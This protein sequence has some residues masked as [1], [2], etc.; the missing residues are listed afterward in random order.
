[1]QLRRVAWILLF[2]GASLFALGTAVFSATGDPTLAN[3]AWP[4]FVAA[5]ASAAGLILA[6]LIPRG[7]ARTRR[8]RG[9]VAAGAVLILA[10]PVAFFFRFRDPLIIVAAVVL[11]VAYAVV[12]VVVLGRRADSGLQGESAA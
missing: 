12:T 9:I 8:A 11:L 4:G 2:V 7:A 6:G 3:V 1:M 5:F 10:G